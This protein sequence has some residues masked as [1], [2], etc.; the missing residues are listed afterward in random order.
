MTDAQLGELMGKLSESPGDFPSHNFVSN[1]TSY[2]DAAKVLREPSM[3]GR[4][5]VGVGPEQNLTYVGLMQPAIAYVVDIRRGNAVEHLVLRS[6]MERG[7]TRVDFVSALTSRRAPDSLLAKGEQASVEEIAEAFRGAKP[8]AS[9]RAEGRAAVDATMAKLG[10]VSTN[11]DRGELAA[12]LGAFEA[13]GMELAYSMEGSARK[14]PTLGSLLARSE[15]DA[16]S[17][18]AREETYRRVREFVVGNRLVPV[19]GDFAGDHALA[20]VGRDLAAR[21]LKLGVFYTSNV[22]QYLFE[23]DKYW[24]FT[25]NVRAMPRDDAS[26]I[27]RVWFDQGRK[28]PKQREGHRTTTLSASVSRFL[29]RAEAKPFRSYWQV[30]TE[31]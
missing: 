23:G 28:H 18:L 26:V 10:W 6:C 9:L 1:E 22:E 4:A 8:D 30:T 20:A 27:V 24:K 3:R 11:A 13:K 12:I 25:A 15:G 17:F 19:V 14:Y 7:K 21:G 16:S 29:E 5:Y 31:E 2:L